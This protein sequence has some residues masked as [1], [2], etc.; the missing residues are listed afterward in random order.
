MK[1]MFAVLV[2]GMVACAAFSGCLESV[3]DIFGGGSAPHENYSKSYEEF[4]SAP[5]HSK[6]YSF[7]VDEGAQSVKVQIS[8]GMIA[9]GAPFPPTAYLTVVI[10]DASG[11]N[12]TDAVNL[13]PVTAASAEFSLSSFTAYGSYSVAVDG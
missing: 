12:A 4:V 9:G 1:E 5:Q 7:P 6:T 3:G 8:L 10:K 11:K 2:A 13:D